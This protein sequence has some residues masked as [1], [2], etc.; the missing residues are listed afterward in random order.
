MGDFGVPARS[1]NNRLA[2]NRRTTFPGGGGAPIDPESILFDNLVSSVSIWATG[3]FFA[4]SFRMEAYDASN[5]LVDFATVDTTPRSYSQL[6]V[7][8][9]EGISK[10]VLISSGS[11]IFLYDDLEYEPIASA[12][13]APEPSGLALAVL[14]GSALLGARRWRSRR[15]HG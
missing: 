15:R 3:G 5:T 6:K 9:A 13:A 11:F 8:H 10:V 7:S 4:S 2:F 1:G 14:G 12:V